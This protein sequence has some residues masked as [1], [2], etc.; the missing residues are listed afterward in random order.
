[1]LVGI[2]ALRDRL[3]DVHNRYGPES[4]NWDAG[5]CHV[6]ADQALLDYINDPEVSKLH[7]AC[8]EFFE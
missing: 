1:M 3:Q 4:E 2:Q 7:G 6:L 8:A 5:T